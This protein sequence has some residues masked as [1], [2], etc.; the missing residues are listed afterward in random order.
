MKIERPLD[1]IEIRVLGSLLEKQQSTPDYY[2]LSL[3]SLRSACNQSTSREPVMD[4]D[5]SRI[6]SAVDRLQ[7]LGLVWR[8]HGS[9]ADKYEHNVDRKWEVSPEMKAILTLLMLRGPQT[10]GELRS[11]S[12]RLHPF[13]SVSEVEAVLQAES[14]A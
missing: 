7:E 14:E 5:D 12:D 9:R 3:S 11:R 13:P 2:P 6:K 8:V 4:L 1:E 10:P